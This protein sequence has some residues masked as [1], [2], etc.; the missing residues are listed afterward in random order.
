MLIGEKQL[1]YLYFFLAGDIALVFLLA[2]AVNRQLNL[3]R[4]QLIAFSLTI[5]PVGLFCG[6]LMRLVEEGTWVGMS[7]YG[8]IL[9]APIMMILVGLLIKIMPSDMLDL[10]APS[11]C[12]ALVFMKI[13]CMITG[14]CA[15]KI[16]RYLDNGR[17]VRFPS[18]IVEMVCGAI[19]LVIILII[20]RSG[21]QRGYVYAWFM[22]LY[23]G[24]R[25][26]LNLFRETEPFLLGLS[27][28]CYWSVVSVM[29]G[30][31]VLVLRA[32][33]PQRAQETN[34]KKM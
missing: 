23:G 12:I 8:A 14:C 28:G 13:Q 29:I 17:P 5:V 22:V 6:K 9:F 33:K 26:V 18:Q 11:G 34:K 16:L 3:E 15:G 19:L 21:K 30:G 7:F 24:S 31:C 25:F 10:C 1:M 4:W 2:M 32:T 27:A 20:I